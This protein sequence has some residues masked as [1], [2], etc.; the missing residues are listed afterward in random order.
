MRAL[1]QFFCIGFCIG[2]GACSGDTPAKVQPW[3]VLLVTLDTTRADHLS[4]YGYDKQ[5]TPNIDAQA[6]RGVRFERA[7][8]TAGLTPMAHASL[9]TGL[10]NYGHGMRVFYSEEVS[11]RMRDSAVT[12]PEVLQARGWRTGAMIASYPV[13]GVYGFEQGF[14]TFGTRELALDELD[15]SKQHEHDFRWHQGTT[16][17]T[18]RRADSVIDEALEWLSAAAEPAPWFLW[19]HLFDVHDSSLVPPADFVAELGIEYDESISPQDVGWR[20]RMY[21]PELTFMDAQLGR[22]FDELEARGELDNTLLVITADHGQGLL[23]GMDRHGWSK[24]RLIYD[25]SIRVPL[26]VV[27]PGE[28]GHAGTSVAAQVRT[29][30]VMPTVLQAIGLPLPEMEGASLQ[31]MIRGQAESSPRI[32]YADALSLRDTFAPRRG[33]PLNCRDNLFAVCDGRWKF[34]R[35]QFNPENNE[36]FDL[37]A[38][39]LELTNVA[40]EHPD[41]IERL[42]EFLIE[43]R[44]L[45]LQA[46]AAGGQSPNAGVLDGLG[47]G[48][49]GDGDEER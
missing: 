29:I 2:L 3:N 7:I 20:D 23:D 38:D 16:T 45:D 22:L 17:G 43:N 25:W 46:P 15:F 48:D 8:S 37:D 32:A 30:D 4:C 28:E 21:D 19:V 6:K 39:P 1:T 47:Y 42:N 11:H 12:L 5:T 44:A 31:S 33:L 26:I 14:D 36:L 35:H 34:I 9:L 24:H 10:N 13:S 27:L 41:I 49:G 40:A 18:Q